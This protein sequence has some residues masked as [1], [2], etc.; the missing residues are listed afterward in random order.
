MQKVTKVLRG[1]L[2]GVLY[3]LL[4]PFI[5]IFVCV[6]FVYLLISLPFENRRYKRSRYY[7]AFGI[8]YRPGITHS[9]GFVFYSSAMKRGLPISFHNCD[10]GKLEYFVFNDTVYLLP[11]FDELGINED[12]GHWEANYDGDWTDF[13]E[14]FSRKLFA[15]RDVLPNAPI[16][17]LLERNLITEPKLTQVELPQQI[18]ITNWYETAFDEENILMDIPQNGQKLYNMML[19]VEDLCGQYELRKDVIYWKIS[20]RIH[21][22][23]GV[24]D[25]DSTISVERGYMGITHWHPSNFEVFRDVCAIGKRGHVLV[26]RAGIFGGDVLYMGPKEDCPYPEN[27]KSLFGKIYYLEAK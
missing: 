20:E 5:L 24:N 25:N 13:H 21:L 14:D 17:I 27:K 3:V 2:V 4:L 18:H 10:S 19:A 6:S 22:E 12:T 8:A 26:L 11:Y 23:I 1:L 15:W 7:Q 9:P 16:K